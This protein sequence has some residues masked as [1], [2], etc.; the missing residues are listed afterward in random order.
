MEVGQGQGNLA[1][2][3]PIFVLLSLGKG[4]EGWKLGIGQFLRPE[5]HSCRIPSWKGLSSGEFPFLEGFQ[6]LWMWG[7]GSGVASAALG[8]LGFSDHRGLFQPKQLLDSIILGLPGGFISGSNPWS[9]K[10]FGKKQE[11]AGEGLDSIPTWRA[12][13][14]SCCRIR[15]DAGSVGAISHFL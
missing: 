10:T 6:S 15:S 8:I 1:G 3:I 9:I 5:E 14:K 13:D 11:K 2:K 12:Q 4:A 7:R